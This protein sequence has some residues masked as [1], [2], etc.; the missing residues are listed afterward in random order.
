[1]GIVRF[2]IEKYQV[3]LGADL[4][5]IVSDMDTKVV[6]IIGCYGKGHQL[7]INF[8]EVGSHMPL[9]EYDEEKRTGAIFVPI[10]QL[11]FYV[12]LLRNEKPLYAYCNNERPEW[13]NISTSHEPV[14]E[15]ER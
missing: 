4:P 2:E 14:G 11:S 12:D 3:T 9:A 5:S 15:G 1:M 6:A 8:V 13:S 7:M 10:S